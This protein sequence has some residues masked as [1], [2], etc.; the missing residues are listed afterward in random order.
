MKNKQKTIR[1]YCLENGILGQIM[2]RLATPERLDKKVDS[3][4]EAIDSFAYNWEELYGGDD[5]WIELHTLVEH[6]EEI[7]NKPTYIEKGN[8]VT[9]DGKEYLLEGNATLV[10]K[11]DLTLEVGKT[12]LVKWTNEFCHTRDGS[13]DNPRQLIFVGS[14]SAG[15]DCGY[16]NIFMGLDYG[17]YYMFGDKD[18]SYVVKK[19][20]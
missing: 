11:E 16:R 9:I 4:S 13:L 1:D 20:N 8:I 15:Q 5:F 10:E 14:V 6:Q 2:L 7:N 19:I 12:Y 3:F 18:L 17:S